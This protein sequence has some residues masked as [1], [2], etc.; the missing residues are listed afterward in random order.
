MAHPRISS[1]FFPNQGGDGFPLGNGKVAMPGFMANIKVIFSKYRHAIYRCDFQANQNKLHVQVKHKLGAFHQAGPVI[2]YLNACFYGNQQ[3][4]GGHRG[5][6]QRGGFQGQGGG[7][8]PGDITRYR[9]FF[10]EDRNVKKATGF[11]KG[12][13][14]SDPFSKFMRF[15][16]MQIYSRST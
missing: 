14:V 16:F 3:Q 4:G 15:V 12:L 2:S 10:Q 8:G 9:Q 1:S 13:T 6:R 11:L 7:D 5:G